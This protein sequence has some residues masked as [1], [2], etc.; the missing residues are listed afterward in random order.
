MYSIITVTCKKMDESD[1]RRVSVILS[2]SYTKTL[3]LIAIRSKFSVQS[4]TPMF[5]GASAHV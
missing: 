5:V 4:R 1:R 3:T 2:V